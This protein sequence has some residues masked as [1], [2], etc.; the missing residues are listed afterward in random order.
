MG[1]KG[2]R[3]ITLTLVSSLCGKKRNL[4]SKEK[5]QELIP[6]SYLLISTI[7]L[8]SYTPIFTC[9]HNIVIIDNILMKH[10]NSKCD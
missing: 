6:D 5:R 4:V 2:V 8:G 3:T 7:K 1:S 9:T 10:K